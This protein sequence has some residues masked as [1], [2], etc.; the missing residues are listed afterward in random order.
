[1]PPIIVQSNGSGNAL[2]MG[3]GGQDN[4]PM[5]TRPIDSSIRRFADMIQAYSLS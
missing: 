1:M 5:T 3:Q 2:P 4:S